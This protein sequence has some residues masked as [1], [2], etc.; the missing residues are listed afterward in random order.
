[1]TST[2]QSDRGRVLIQTFMDEVVYEQEGRLIT[3]IKRA[4]TANR[5]CAT[6]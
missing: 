6:S 4:A 5:I 3:M 1:M 2:D